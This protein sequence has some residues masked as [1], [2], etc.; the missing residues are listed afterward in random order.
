M[1][2]R[3]RLIGP[4]Y[5]DFIQNR[6]PMLFEDLPIQIRRDLIYMHDG[7][8]PHFTLPVQNHLNKNYPGRK[9]G[10]RKYTPV[11]WPPR[12]PNFS[13]MDWFL[14]G[15]L[16]GKVYS[17]P[18]ETQEELWERTVAAADEIRPIPNI[19]SSVRNSVLRQANIR[20]NRKH[21]EH[22]SKIIFEFCLMFLIS[23]M[24]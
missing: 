15:T 18:V 8:P 14:S 19:F 17:T 3:A 21:F 11:Q 1:V 2:I 10:R 6:L 24:L 23:F 12:S 5:L 16:K 22:Y 13:P 7:A 20:Q 9:I 4:F